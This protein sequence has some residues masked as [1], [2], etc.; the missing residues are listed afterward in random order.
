MTFRPLNLK[1]KNI[2]FKFFF[3]WNETD[4]ELDLFEEVS[5]FDEWHG[6]FAPFAK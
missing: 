1:F 6:R 4:V 3:Q 2:R 5:I